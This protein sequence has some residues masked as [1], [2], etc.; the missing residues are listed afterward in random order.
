VADFRDNQGK[1][2]WSTYRTKKEADDALA[3]VRR[4]L[5]EGAYRDPATLPT[6]EQVARDWLAVKRDH[7]ASS[8][9]FW[10]T[11]VE[12][13]FV[14]AFG[15]LRIDQVMVRDI[16][17]FRNAKRDG[18]NGHQQLARATV[19]QVLQTLTAILE[20]AVAHKYLAGNP[21]KQVM[22]VRAER[23]AG[24]AGVQAVDPREVLT[25]EQAAAV[26]EASK[27]G[28]YRMF[29]TTA[30]HTGAR[31]G[32]L[33]ALNWE[34]FDLEGG[35]MRIERSLSWVRGE[36]RGYGKNKPLFGPPKTDSS[37]RTLDLAP[38]LVHELKAWRLRSRYSRGEELVFPNTL[39]KP[40]HRAFLHKGLQLAIEKA[41]IG[42]AGTPLPHMSVHGLRHSFASLM[43]QLGKP[44]S[45]VSQI[46]GHKDPSLTL[47]VYTHWFSGASSASAMADLSAAIRRPAVAGGSKMVADT[48]AG[49]LAATK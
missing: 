20:Y 31:V 38:D 33:L 18:S 49:E 44:V 2:H 47:K 30:L 17:R 37:Y 45:Q 15:H 7:P 1:R 24:A 32:E 8:F 43:I 27:P 10:Q 28:L 6:F 36:E 3:D 42:R 12:R 9:M 41:N 11:Q 39:G 19:N 21:G 35:T 5:R 40:L 13:H 14:P 22:R 16:E 25:A 48:A 46:L 4:D 23:R 26:I 29:I 34:H